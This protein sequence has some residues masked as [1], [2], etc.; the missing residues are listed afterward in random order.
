M[1]E[2]VTYPKLWNLVQPPRKECLLAFFL[3]VA[4]GEKN[5]EGSQKSGT[6]K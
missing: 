1:E 5:E 3:I 6:V 2:L 4:I